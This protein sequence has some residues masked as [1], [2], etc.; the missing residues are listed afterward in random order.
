MGNRMLQPDR[1]QRRKGSCTIA[2]AL[3]VMSGSGCGKQTRVETQRPPPPTASPNAADPGA[4]GAAHDKPAP[5]APIPE[6]AWSE[7][8]WLEVTGALPDAPGA[9]ATGSFDQDNNKLVIDTHD[10]RRF[11][12]NTDMIPIDW[13]RR[14][15][16]SL[17][18]TNT[19][20]RRRES[21]LLTFQ[22]DEHNRWVI[23]EPPAR[24][25]E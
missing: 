5:V 25:P 1:S 13:D 21:S 8:R 20:L 15:I 9:W 17:N 22:L 16:L 3:F 12:V 10:A 4:G 6:R 14:V 19:E 2:F 11:V 7:D 18:G 24:N 23:L